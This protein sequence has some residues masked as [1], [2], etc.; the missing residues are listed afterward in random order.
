MRD[1]VE[2][3]KGVESG[4]ITD[5]ELSQ[6]LDREL[7]VRSFV[8]PTN[9]GPEGETSSDLDVIPSKGHGYEVVENAPASM[10]GFA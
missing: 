7:V 9:D 5:T 8:R 6:I 10:E 1:D 3:R 2:I 4:G